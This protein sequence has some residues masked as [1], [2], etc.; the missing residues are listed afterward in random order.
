MDLGSLR[1]LQYFLPELLLA[2][3]ILTILVLDL[4]V[5]DKWWFGDLALVI[6]AGALLLIGL[7]PH[8]PGAWLFHRMLV[9]DA[10]GVFFRALIAL[11][12]LVA[13]WMSI[14]S[15]EVRGCE[16]GEYYAILLASTLAMF[17]MAESA[18][19]LMAYIALEFVS[20]TSYILTGFLRH[21][22]RSQ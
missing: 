20:L 4:I 14:G 1:S 11:G 6:T 18:N 9:F 10:F 22:R 3:G 7:E 12:A 2:G 16:Q 8:L 21:N 17:L 13:V 15:E 5:R 19:L